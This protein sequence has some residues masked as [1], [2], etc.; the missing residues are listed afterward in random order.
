MTPPLSLTCVPLRA[1]AAL[2]FG[3][4]YPTFILFLP[5][6]AK[7]RGPRR[8]PGS[9]TGA[10]ARR[11]RAPLVENRPGVAIRRRPAPYGQI[12]GL[13][14]RAA[15]A[16]LHARRKLRLENVS[17][18][19]I[20][21]LRARTLLRKVVSRAYAAR[22][23]GF[24]VFFAPARGALRG[25]PELAVQ[26]RQGRQQ[27]RLLHAP[28][29]RERVCARG[30]F[31]VFG[32][33]A[34]VF[35][36]LEAPRVQP[37]DGRQE[38]RLLRR[39]RRGRA[40]PVAGEHAVHEPLAEGRAAPR[41]VAQELRARR[42]SLGRLREAHARLAPAVRRHRLGAE[43][44]RSRRRR[45][46][47]E[48]RAAVAAAALAAV[49]AGR[50]REDG[51]VPVP[52]RVARARG[53]APPRP[54]PP[55]APRAPQPRSPPAAAPRG[56]GATPPRRRRRRTSPPVSVRAPPPRAPL[57]FRARRQPG[58]RGGAPT[59]PTPAWARASARTR[60][61]AASPWAASPAASPRG[62]PSGA[63]G[64]TRPPP[65]P[66]E[67]PS[68]PPR[69]RLAQHRLVRVRERNARAH[70]PHGALA[71]DR[72]RGRH[73]DIPGGGDARA[74]IGAAETTARARARR[75]FRVATGAPWKLPC[76]LP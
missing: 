36:A 39:Q 7:G 31:G 28:L 52:R 76:F 56:G 21:L 16:R 45:R 6:G 14:R 49:A 11:R 30:V 74:G 18:A 75:A 1:D 26:S 25:R 23:G 71:R 15:R 32:V 61:P 73:G 10:R 9:V 57:S 59:S 13:A 40:S 33:F 38:L 37:P 5:S 48:G 43:R 65:E 70:E 27:R 8:R 68:A 42:A 53:S 47:R 55:R 12:V 67:P 29:R 46:R 66:P 4:T 58:S 64:R 17:C 51:V 3:G 72:D 54:P 19:S 44:A 69:R 50:G 60:R 62:A 63:R 20:V 41:V 34:G 24:A 35:V 2:A 22:F